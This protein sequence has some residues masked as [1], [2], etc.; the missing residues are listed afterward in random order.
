V[1]KI[2]TVEMSVQT[3]SAFSPAL[4]E[5]VRRITRDEM[6]RE[7]ARRERESREPDQTAEGEDDE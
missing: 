3:H 2:E 4:E 5:E 1:A 7:L 6:R